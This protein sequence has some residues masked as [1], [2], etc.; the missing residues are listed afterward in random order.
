MRKTKKGYEWE[1]DPDRPA[2]AVNSHGIEVK[3]WCQSCEHHKFDL[4][5]HH[6]VK[7][8][9]TDEYHERHTICA[10]WKMAAYLKRVGDPS[11]QKMWK[12]KEYFRW[13][14]NPKNMVACASGEDTYGRWKKEQEQEHKT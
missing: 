12:P 4:H 5:R 1:C 6:L 11:N 2:V 9:L 8:G 3:K 14:D 7:C 13:L 10:L